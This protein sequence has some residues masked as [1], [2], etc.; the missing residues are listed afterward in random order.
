MALIIN[1]FS[2]S[3]WKRGALEYTVCVNHLSHSNASMRQ[4]FL[5][6]TMTSLPVYLSTLLFLV[7][8]LNSLDPLRVSC[9]YIQ[10]LYH[11]IFCTFLSH[12]LMAS[13]TPQCLHPLSSVCFIPPD[14]LTAAL[15]LFLW[16]Q[17]LQP[18]ELNIAAASLSKSADYIKSAFPRSIQLQM[19]HPN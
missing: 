1:G 3:L 5:T 10:F 15:L 4:L 6:L 18:A 9:I 2:W 16:L 13:Q 14:F 17:R 7:L 8:I 11:I 12:C 19:A